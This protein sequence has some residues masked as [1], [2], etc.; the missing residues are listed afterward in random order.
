MHLKVLMTLELVQHTLQMVDY[1]YEAQNATTLGQQGL[2]SKC[3]DTT[4]RIYIS[5][6]CSHF[7]KSLNL[8]RL[9]FGNHLKPIF[10]SFF[11]VL[12][13]M[14]VLFKAFLIL[15]THHIPI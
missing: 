13:S 1:E 4:N 11:P 9:N 3:L 15:L 8:T 10:A 14:F 6:V 2:G 7:S 12:H 5:D